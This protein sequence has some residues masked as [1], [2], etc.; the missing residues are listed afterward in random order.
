MVFDDADYTI[1][2]RVH[3]DTNTPERTLLSAVSGYG[4][5]LFEYKDLPV[6]KK[7]TVLRVLVKR[8]L[9]HTDGTITIDWK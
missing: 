5:V 7:Q 1:G 8:V 4:D 6:E 2:L 3:S 9:L